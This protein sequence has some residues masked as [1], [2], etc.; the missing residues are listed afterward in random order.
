MGSDQTP[1]PVLGQL[2][3]VLKGK[4]SG[5]YFVIVRLIDHRFVEIADGDKRK[6]DNAKKKNISHLE[7]QSYISVE[8]QKSLRE[9]GRVTNG[10]LRFAIAHYLDGE[11]SNN[12]KG[13]SADG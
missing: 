4:E 3:R 10:K 11:I 8:V 6:F 12:R 2:A 7:L 9:I 13:E 5:S 1:L